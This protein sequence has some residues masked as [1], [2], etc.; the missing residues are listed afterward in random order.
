M[1]DACRAL[2]TPVTGGN[3]SFYN[4][5]E[6]FQ[7]YPTPVIGMI[8]IIEDLS[9]ITSSDFQNEGDLVY[10]IGQTLPEIGG[11]EYLKKE[12]DVVVGLPPK[13]DLKIEKKSQKSFKEVI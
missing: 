2:N 8:G 4:E 10:L 3:V 9:Y 7:V 12:F 6:T 11:S 13:I 1:G 5:S